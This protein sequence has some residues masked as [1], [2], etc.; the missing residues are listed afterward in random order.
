MKFF[1]K[2]LSFIFLFI[3]LCSPKLISAQDDGPV[4]FFSS[5]GHTLQGEFLAFYESVEDAEFL[6]GAPITESF[7]YAT[8]ERE[9]QFFENVRLEKNDKLNI[10]EISSIGSHFFEKDLNSVSKIPFNLFGCSRYSDED[11][12]DSRVCFEF[13]SFYEKYGAENFFGYP[14]SE[15]FEENG[16]IKQYFE[17]VVMEWHPE[18]DE[19]SVVLGNLGRQ[20]LSILNIDVNDFALSDQILEL[21]KMDENLIGYV[22]FD[23]EAIEPGMS[24][25]LFVYVTNKF[26][27]PQKNV[28]VDAVFTYPNG[29]IYEE[30]LALTNDIGLT[31]F[32]FSVP[33][34]SQLGE[35]RVFV[36]VHMMNEAHEFVVFSSFLIK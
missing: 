21:E 16:M 22:S 7:Y 28:T 3:F 32:E 31:T 9:V 12:F 23:K 8:I 15:M 4:R 30:T 24:Q 18:N 26:D 11:G 1:R 33:E 36:E 2:I 27:F 10:V 14:I 35:G 29:K 17:N 6:F 34:N 25:K 5:T 20:Y 13:R 19:S